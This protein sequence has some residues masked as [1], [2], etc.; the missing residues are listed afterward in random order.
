MVKVPEVLP[1]V[2]LVQQ[3]QALNWCWQN[4]VT[5]RISA[6]NLFIYDLI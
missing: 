4:F 2:L 6:W 1:K 5:D 3:L